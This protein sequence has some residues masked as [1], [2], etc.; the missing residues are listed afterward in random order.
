MHRIALA[1]QH[2]LHERNF[3]S[4]FSFMKKQNITPSVLIANGSD[5]HKL[6]L[7]SGNYNHIDETISPFLARSILNESLVYRQKSENELYALSIFNIRVWPICRSELLSFLLTKSN[8][9]KD[10]FKKDDRLIFNK[11]YQEN[12]NDLVLNLAAASFW[13]NHWHDE[14]SGIFSNNI[15]CVF[16]G[17]QTYTRS[18]MEILRRGPTKCFVM[19]SVFT[20]ND[21][22]F[23]EMYHPVANNLPVS[24]PN[25]RHMRRNQTLE[26]QNL[27][28]REVIKARNKIV[29][30]KNKN[31]QQPR[32]CLVP[33]FSNC[34]KKS[35]LILGQVVNDFSLIEKGFPYVSS[36]PVYKELI[37]QILRNTNYNII[38][39]AHPWEN[40]KIHVR[41]AMTFNAVADF[42]KELS[43]IDRGRIIVVEDV[44]LHILLEMV[45]YFVTFCSQGGIEA[46]LLGLRPFVLGRA[47]Y[48]GAGFTCDC[49]DL[50]SLVSKLANGDGVLNLKEYLAFDRFIVDFFQYNTISVFESGEKEIAKRLVRSTPIVQKAPIRSELELAGPSAIHGSAG[51]G[52]GIVRRKVPLPDGALSADLLKNVTI[53]IATKAKEFYAPGSTIDL[54]V[55]IFNDTD[56]QIESKGGRNFKLSYHIFSRD[57]GRYEWNGV[58]TPLLSI[59][60]SRA[61]LSLRVNVPSDTG[62]YRIVPAILLPSAFWI[63]A[64]EPWEITV[65]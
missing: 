3:P 17:S 13:L 9:Q 35:V 14:R 18:L 42:L 61:S 63:D 27:Y 57:G 46:A 62:V 44:N 12:L 50:S 5:T 19:E 64:N 48:S 1:D 36:I 15:C 33:A 8:W 21:Y 65:E 37:M 38:F 40:K 29:D 28:D 20:G 60:G 31:V 47:F 52:A 49:E 16:S 41:S 43:A 55:L 11:A 26:V 30:A 25:V 4:L 59:A 22:I 32:D 51:E 53:K 23:E 54:R 34:S 45:D 24:I 7:A 10:V 56:F 6:I 39:K 58:Q 2:H